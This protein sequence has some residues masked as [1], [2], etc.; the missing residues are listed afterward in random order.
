M[1]KSAAA[2]T[3]RTRVLLMRTPSRAMVAAEAKVVPHFQVHHAEPLDEDLVDELV[4][5]KLAQA[6]V[7]GQAQHLIDATGAQQ[8]ELLAQAGNPR[9]GLVGSKELARL[10]L[11]DHHAAGQPGLRRTLAQA[12]QDALVTA[13]HAIEIA[14]G[15]GAATLAGA[16]IMET[17]DQLHN[18]HLARKVVDY[19]Q[20]QAQGVDLRQPIS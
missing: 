10:R 5:G 17:S 2:S 6:A 16:Q 18:T 14:D 12:R 4:G 9:R 15:S 19:A 7:E 20:A 11:E 1:A 13:V 8:F 3:S